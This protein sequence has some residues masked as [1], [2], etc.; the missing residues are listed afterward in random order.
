MENAGAVQ[1]HFGKNTGKSLDSLS[2]RSLAWYATEQP[3]RLD[4]SGKPYPPRQVE[5]T[6][7]NAARTLWHTRAGTLGT[8]A[9]QVATALVTATATGSEDNV[10]F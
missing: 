9:V 4:S 3:P 10:P 6:L 8:Q 1:I 7:R 2:E 5:I